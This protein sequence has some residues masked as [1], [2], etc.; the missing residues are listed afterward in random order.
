MGGEE[1]WN[2]TKKHRHRHH[3]GNLEN[4]KKTQSQTRPFNYSTVVGMATQ[5]LHHRD[6]TA[7]QVCGALVRFISVLSPLQLHF[8][9]LSTD[10]EAIHGLDGA[11]SRQWVVVADETKA[12]TEAS[13]FVYKDFGTDD[14]AKRLEHLDQVHVL[15]VVRE[16]VDEQVAPLGTWDYI[17]ITSPL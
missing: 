5:Q 14:T 17:I 6:I 1:E 10:L 3:H 16:V 7:H 2:S 13:V 12:F 4:N 15:H 8:Q 9:P 11:L